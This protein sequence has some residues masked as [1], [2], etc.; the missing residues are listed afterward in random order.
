VRAL[1]VVELDEVVAEVLELGGGGGLV[2][3]GSQ[4]VL[5]RLLEPFD[6]AAGGR[7]VRAAVLLGDAEVAEFGFEGVAAAAAAGQAG[8]ED[9]AVV[10]ERRGWWAVL[11]GR[12]PERG[13]DDR[14]GDPVMRGD[15]QSATGVVIEPGEDLVVLA[16]GQRVVGEAAGTS[17]GERPSTTTAVITTRAL[18]TQERQA[19]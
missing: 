5:E 3:L 13:D 16:R 10:G 15:R 8:G 4:P 14:S 2:G 11:G 19:T 18:D 9:H 6:L 12:S 17:V 1:V 7:V